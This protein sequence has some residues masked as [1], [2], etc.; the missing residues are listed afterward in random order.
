MLTAQ[1][2]IMS[3][4]GKLTSLHPEE[5][6]KMGDLILENFPGIKKVEI[7]NKTIVIKGDK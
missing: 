7:L 6:K 2:T 5:S 4:D 3:I 1:I